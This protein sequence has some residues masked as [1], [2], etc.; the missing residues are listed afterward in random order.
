MLILLRSSMSQFKT[1]VVGNFCYIMLEIYIALFFRLNK[2][3]SLLKITISYD[4]Y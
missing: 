3:V 4:G 1:R 2:I